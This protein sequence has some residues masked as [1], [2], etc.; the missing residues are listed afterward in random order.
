MGSSLEGP[1]CTSVVNKLT[2]G[3]PIDDALLRALETEFCPQVR[4]RPGFVDVH[5]VVV[6]ETEAIVVGLYA[7]REAM[8]DISRNV[9]APW[10]AQHVRPY[11]AGPVQRSTGE[12]VASTRK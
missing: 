8:D 4:D 6:S 11:L 5:L 7:T 12:V 9:A 2:L 3:K 1:T 10:F